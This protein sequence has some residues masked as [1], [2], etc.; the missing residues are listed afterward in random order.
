MKDPGTKGSDKTKYDKLKKA[1]LSFINSRFKLFKKNILDA[2]QKIELADEHKELAEPQSDYGTIIN[3]RF[4]S[5][6]PPIKCLNKEQLL[7]CLKNYM[8]YKQATTD[9]AEILNDLSHL[10]DGA[11]G[12]APLVNMSSYTRKITDKDTLDWVKSYCRRYEPAIV[13]FFETVFNKLINVAHMGETQDDGMFK[14]QILHFFKDP[15]Q[16]DTSESPVLKIIPYDD[17]KVTSFFGGNPSDGKELNF[18]IDT[19]HISSMN[20]VCTIAG[21]WDAALKSCTTQEGDNGKEYTGE[22][23]EA[24]LVAQAFTKLNLK[25]EYDG[26]TE[27]VTYADGNKRTDNPKPFTAINRSVGA[28]SKCIFDEASKD[29]TC[30]PFGLKIK[31]DEIKYYLDFKRTGDAY[32]VLMVKKLNE[33]ANEPLNVFVTIDHLAFL[34]A[35]MVG[36]PAIYSLFPAGIF[37]KEGKEKS[38]IL[39]NPGST[40]KTTGIQY[41][42]KQYKSYRDKIKECI[43]ESNKDESID[44]NQYIDDSY[45]DKYSEKV[46]GVIN[47]LKGL[48]KSQ[49]PV[50]L[51]TG[52]FT[53][54]GT[55][56]GTALGTDVL[57][58]SFISS[59]NTEIDTVINKLPQD[60][61]NRDEI[62]TQFGKIKTD[63]KDCVVNYLQNHLVSAAVIDA[64]T[65]ILLY[66]RFKLNKTAMIQ[67]ITEVKNVYDNIILPDEASDYPRYEAELHVA[68]TEGITIFKKF[69]QMYSNENSH[70]F[71]MIKDSG[72]FIKAYTDFVTGTFN[73][74]MNKHMGEFKR[75]MGGIKYGVTQRRLPELK[76]KIMSMIDK[77]TKATLIQNMQREVTDWIHEQIECDY[78][79]LLSKPGE[80]EIGE[81]SDDVPLPKSV[82]DLYKEFKGEGGGGRGGGPEGEGGPEEGEGVVMG[83]VNEEL[84]NN[85]SN[86][87]VFKTLL[88]IDI[89][90]LQDEKNGQAA[91]EHMKE[92]LE[93]PNAISYIFREIGLDPTSDEVYRCSVELCNK[94]DEYMKSYT[95]QTQGMTSSLWKSPTPYTPDESPNETLELE[96][97]L[98]TALDELS[99]VH[100]DKLRIDKEIST[101]KMYT[102]LNTYLSYNTH[103]PYQDQFID[104][105]RIENFHKNHLLYDTVKIPEFAR[106]A[107]END[108]EFMVFANLK[109]LEP[110]FEILKQNLFN[111]SFRFVPRQVIMAMKQRIIKELETEGNHVEKHSRLLQLKKIDLDYSS[112][113]AESA[114]CPA[115]SGGAGAITRY[116]LADYCAKYYRPYYDLYYK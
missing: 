85:I 8:K 73:T 57:P 24:Q 108:H 29:G 100:M 34:K 76:D 99:D 4:G 86:M 91:V 89:E 111:P 83:T 59:F 40:P 11:E 42:E 5:T 80:G 9:M 15:L 36:V 77:F 115:T 23:Y 44:I 71:H 22:D 3:T 72:N 112:T 26:T 97:M 82:F 68:C 28:L 92:S 46:N 54:L 33:V 18:I 53:T 107:C 65:K 103:A 55:T 50:S 66:L 30:Q 62:K 104:K 61:V 6:V 27:T 64:F 90:E 98:I 48:I 96:L 2:M 37:A 79:T 88:D 69:L 45:F 116:T 78:M 16:D 60:L 75:M 21:N 41:L 52:V 7:A 74:H 58:L 67:Q 81:I 10:L 51:T 87:D 43:K 84:R 101:I 56:L 113:C 25:T 109:L 47:K 35:R 110:G 19:T 94:V 31:K 20:G 102:L 106:A 13:L 32:Q 105:L 14:N 17:Q 63:F 39:F 70:S 114:K 38:V 49:Q 12:A 95:G 93:F 1:K